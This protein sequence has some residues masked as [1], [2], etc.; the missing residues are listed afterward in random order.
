M[1]SGCFGILGSL[2]RYER[3]GGQ[4]TRNEQVLPDAFSQSFTITAV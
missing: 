2:T 4:E 3:H 1:E